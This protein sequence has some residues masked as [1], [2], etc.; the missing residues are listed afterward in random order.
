MSGHTEDTLLGGR[1]RLRQR[2]DGFRAAVDPVLLAAFVPARPGQRVLEAG[3]GSGAAF[4]CLASRVSGL[5]VLAVERDP[6]LAALA[7]HNA[8]AN[9]FSRCVTV[10]EDDVRTA[11]PGDGF[12]HAFANPPFWPTGTAPPDRSRAAATHEAEADLS[13]WVRFLGRGLKRHGTL[14]LILPAARFDE[15]VSALREAGCGAITLLPLL[16]REG[17][18][19]R[20]VLLRGIS[21]SRA[22]AV[23]QPA[24]VLHPPGQGYTDAAERVLRGGEP[25][26]TMVARG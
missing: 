23:L 16:P 22:P 13:D 19:A 10:I 18:A 2:R 17:A 7:R 4:L 9:G 11:D 20:R 26:G 21:G 1:V 5:T 24:F 12:D 15:G 14:S 8:A 6:A 3:C 25:I